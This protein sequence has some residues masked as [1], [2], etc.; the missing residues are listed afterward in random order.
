TFNWTGN[1]SAERLL[2]RAANWNFLSLLGVK[3]Q[4]GRDF[5]SEDDQLAVDHR[6]LISDGLWKRRF[7]GDPNVLGR[8][9]TLDGHSHTIIGVLPEGFTYAG[10]KDDI[11][12]PFTVRTGPN[13]PFPSRGNHN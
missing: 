9:M 4:L 11:Y 5:T 13:S 1:G 10:R 12:E 3:P 2:G 7:G 6:I 8:Q